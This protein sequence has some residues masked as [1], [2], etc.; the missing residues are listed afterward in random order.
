ML[1]RSDVEPFRRR[2][3][4]RGTQLS[5][6]GA[7]LEHRHLQASAPDP[8]RGPSRDT[9][10]TP[11]PEFR[12]GRLPRQ[13]EGLQFDSDTFRESSKW[14][15]PSSPATSLPTGRSTTAQASELLRADRRGARS[16][17][18][19]V[20]ASGLPLTAGNRDLVSILL[21]SQRTIKRSAFRQIV[22]CHSV[23]GFGRTRKS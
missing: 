13:G 3:Q 17:R 11:P 1:I 6:R 12:H 19:C 18:E 10:V 5:G 22:Q 8:D 4:R 15:R 9:S 16:P 20:D 7:S 23:S 21:D 2:S 14:P